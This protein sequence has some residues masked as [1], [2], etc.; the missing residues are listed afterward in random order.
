[1]STVT[2]RGKQMPPVLNAMGIACA[3]CGNHDFNFGDDALL[4][5]KGACDFPWLISNI[6][7]ARTTPRT[8]GWPAGC[9]PTWSRCRAAALAAIPRGKGPRR[10]RGRRCGSA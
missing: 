3:C 9:A 4:R 2:T 5:L 1:M 10:P 8:G 7:D 6:A